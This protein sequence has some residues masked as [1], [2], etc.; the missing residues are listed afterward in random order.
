MPLG[1]SLTIAETGAPA[2][3]AVDRADSESCAAWRSFARQERVLI[4][5]N[6]CILV[7]L[8]VIHIGFSS[9]VGQLSI[10]AYLLLCF[11]FVMQAVEWM[12]LSS[13][14]IRGSSALAR[15]YG[16]LSIV[17]N[18][19]FAAAL[20][21]VSQIESSHY[22]V[23]MLI[24]IIAAAF[25]MS[26]PALIVTTTAASALAFVEVYVFYERHPPLQP[27][28]YF[29]AATVA[30]V[31]VVAATIVRLLG[32]QLRERERRLEAALTQ[33]HAAQDALVEGER[34]AAVGRLSSSLAHEIRN[35][36][37]MI[38]A[39]LRR[40]RS[41]APSRN[42][43]EL[44]AIAEAESGKLERI[45][46][47]FLQ[48][49]RTPTPVLRST[50]LRSVASAVC[51]IA[52]ASAEEASIELR[53]DLPADP[54][55]LRLD[56]TQLHR[57][58]LNLVRNAMEAT[59]PLGV[60]T[61]SAGRRGSAA[62]LSVTNPGEQIPAEFVDRLFEPFATTRAGG[63]GLGLPIARSIAHLHGGALTLANNEPGNV[64]FEI[65]LPITDHARATKE[66]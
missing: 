58:L 34:L 51:D 6:L 41:G 5:L 27:A 57:A 30:L 8:V 50:D 40:V 23:L 47:D 7:M 14:A 60:I 2:P 25:R 12:L 61:I 9:V 46:T 38:G 13:G 66:P 42:S 22:V 65:S 54:V 43:D 31:Y 36:V 45:T 10:A 3:R 19:A 18:I 35:P 17:I 64:R 63:T 56:A 20:S 29:E 15:V 37:A 33:L 52:S 44:V 53:L 26:T 1:R 16:S 28:E 32:R 39:S 24:P 59:G 21:I 49:A 4:A 11:R 62:V 55:M 48:Y